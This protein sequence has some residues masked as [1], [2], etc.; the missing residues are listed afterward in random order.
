[1]ALR[2]RL[3]LRQIQRLGLSPG[4]MAALGILRM[5]AAELAEE[6]GR[7]AAVNPFLKPGLP[8]ALPR[9]D[10]GAD[11]AGLDRLA[12]REPDW[13]VGLLRQI[14]QRTLAPGLARLA[15]LLVGEL[16]ERGWLD[17][18][19]DQIAA[20]TGADPDMLAQALA[21]VQACEPAGV[22]ARDLDECLHLQLVAMGLTGP[23]ARATLD[24]LP[25]FARRD[26]PGLSRR[27][28]LAPDQVQ[29]RAA[30]LRRVSAHPVSGAEGPAR[31]LRPD[32]VV[33]RGATGA[34]DVELSRADVPRP[35]VDLALARRAEAEG[36]GGDLLDRAR[37]M[38]RATESRAST[39]LRV[40]QWLVRRQDPALRDGPGALRAA[41]R[42][43]CAQ[44]LGLH[45]STIGRA[46]AGKALQADGRLWPLSAL[47]SGP[48]P[49]TADRPDGDDAAADAPAAARA[50]AHR[51]AALIA[52][53]PGLHP[54]SDQAI[55]QILATE[56]V[57]IARR[58]VAKYRTG[59]RIPPAHLRRNRG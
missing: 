40:G 7:E 46:V 36:F 25:L 14:A 9:P 31:I 29:A 27:L 34:V 24:H 38:V 13:Q 30:L 10:L 11:D 18:P 6:L 20:T 32:L 37:A 19:L 15:A 22:G 54:R 28:G 12:A 17:T 45:P 41:T 8:A 3:E 1:M 21:V 59:L 2:T 49:G 42:A 44:A 55:A 26:W 52:A 50:V 58:T 5:S 33:V 16:D 57:D 23:E 4:V 35:S 47:F 48:A 43:E 39:L 56:G 53:E 51:I